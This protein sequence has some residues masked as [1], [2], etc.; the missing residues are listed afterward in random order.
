MAKINASGL[1]Y[2]SLVASGSMG[3]DNVMRP[4]CLLGRPKT[5]APPTCNTSDEHGNPR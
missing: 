1:L 3:S 4:S 5:P 2:K